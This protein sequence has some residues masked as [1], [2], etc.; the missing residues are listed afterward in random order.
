MTAAAAAAERERKREDAGRKSKW[1]GPSSAS[2]A[3]SLARRRVGEKRR[4][5]R[6]PRAGG[7]ETRCVTLTLWAQAQ[8]RPFY[9]KAGYSAEGEQF[10]DAGI[11]HIAMSKP[12]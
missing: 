11:P 3:E 7:R 5:A 2:I 1:H 6:V 10:D 9:E 8:A 12:A 4:R